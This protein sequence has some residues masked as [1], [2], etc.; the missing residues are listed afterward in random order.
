MDYLFA[1][2]ADVKARIE[3]LKG[4][5]VDE[6]TGGFLQLDAALAASGARYCGHAVTVFWWLPDEPETYTMIYYVVPT[7]YRIRGHAYHGAVTWEEFV[8]LSTTLWTAVK[9][10]WQARHGAGT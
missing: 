5:Y 6:R 8:Q 3:R 2:D 9:E 1:V 10:W 7:E 4:G